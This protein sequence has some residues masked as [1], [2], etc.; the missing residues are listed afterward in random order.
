MS[1]V[2]WRPYR[3]GKVLSLE[4]FAAAESPKHLARRYR[5]ELH[6]YVHYYVIPSEFWPR[7]VHMRCVHPSFYAHLTRKKGRCAPPP[8]H[9]SFAASLSS[10]KNIYPGIEQAVRVVSSPSSGKA[11]QEKLCYAENQTRDACVPCEYSTT[12]PT[13][14][15]EQE[16]RKLALAKPELECITDPDPT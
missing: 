11:P 1:T 7:F 16:R 3:V 13:S 8:A 2:V 10:S 9:R 15:V 14:V 12:G 4:S 6:C 5:T